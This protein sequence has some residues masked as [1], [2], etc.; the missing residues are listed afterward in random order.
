MDEN[1]ALHAKK[2]A[3]LSEIDGI[4]KGC[5][6]WN[7]LEEIKLFLE[8]IL[9]T[10]GIDLDS[11]RLNDSGPVRIIDL[12]SGSGVYGI[13]LAALIDRPCEISFID[14][15][16]EYHE[17]AINATERVLGETTTATTH[18][19]S[20]DNTDLP[21]DYFDLAV[22]ADGF[23]HCPS[24]ELALNEA[25]RVIK[26]NGIFIG[27]DRI[28]PNRITDSKIN[29]L[30]NVRYPKEWL[31]KYGYKVESLTRREN[32]ENEIRFTEW[33]EPLKLKGS[34]FTYIEY[35]KTGSDSLKMWALS[36]APWILALLKRKFGGWVVPPRWGFGLL[37]TVVFGVSYSLRKRFY[38]AVYRS[39]PMNAQSSM[40]RC[41]VIVA[42]KGKAHA[43]MTQG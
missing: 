43:N 20:A 5:T 2:V 34:Y 42:E 11:I 23:H 16:G 41:Q 28:H 12:C 22:E 19:C 6:N 17:T 4:V 27:I 33:A 25:W 15:V 7:S 39:F 24:V 10:V 26:S 1:R 37:P 13:A 18:T 21:D 29:E 36:T 35:V 9:S 30:L 31:E 32:G 40:K 8:D 14:I 3:S 38:K